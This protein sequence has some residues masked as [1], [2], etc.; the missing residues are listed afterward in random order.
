[1]A[2]LK[3]QGRVWNPFAERMARSEFRDRVRAA[4]RG[5]LEPVDEVKPVDVRNPPPLYEIRWQDI[6]VTDRDGDRIVHG[7]ALVRMYH[8]E[9][10]AVPDHFVGHHI[11]EKL[12]DVEDVN[13]KQNAEIRVALSFY[14]L[15]E[16]TGWGID[17]D[18]GGV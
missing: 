15:G 10:T 7:T 11:H 13:R 17:I 8:S 14:R 4:A 6:P 18:T 12:I 1:M 2:A 3:P 5:E 9:P 16:S